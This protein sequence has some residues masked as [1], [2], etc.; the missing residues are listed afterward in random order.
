MRIYLLRHGEAKSE[1]QD[2]QRHLTQKGIEDVRRVA[3]LLIPL[4]LKVKAIWHSGKA[5]AAQT[6]EIVVGAVESEEEVKQQAGLAPNDPVEPIVEAVRE[7]GGDLMLVGHLPFLGK[8]ASALVI[9]DE[10]SGVLAI[11]SAGLVCLDFR[12]E[13]GWRVAW[14]VV[15][16]LLS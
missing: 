13:V 9:G 2:P 11:A 12:E 6:A 8:F 3:Q 16:D 1:E 5:R 4:D 10:A 7:V 15:P 14:M